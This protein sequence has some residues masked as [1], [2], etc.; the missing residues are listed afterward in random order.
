[1]LRHN[2]TTAR[3]REN[4]PPIKRPGKPL[5][6]PRRK[7]SDKKMSDSNV[8]YDSPLSSVPFLNN[9]VEIIVINHTFF[10]SWLTSGTFL[11]LF[12]HSGKESHERN[13]ERRELALSIRVEIH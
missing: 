3:R 8:I 13:D 11:A 2:A 1:V 9:K 10:L 7:A 4:F 5:F 12:T 6:E